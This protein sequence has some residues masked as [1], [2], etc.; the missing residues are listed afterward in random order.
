MINWYNCR[1]V[2]S[3]ILNF[4]IESNIHQDTD[5]HSSYHYSNH[6]SEYILSL[7]Q[8]KKNTHFNVGFSQIKHSNI[9][10][11]KKNLKNVI[12][13]FRHNSTNKWFFFFRGKF[14]HKLDWA[15]SHT[16]YTHRVIWLDNRSSNNIRTIKGFECRKIGT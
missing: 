16:T 11:K 8:F 5:S 3:V 12:L 1:N 2:R 6:T 15:F 10:S 13:L 9:F 4:Y 7:E 14:F